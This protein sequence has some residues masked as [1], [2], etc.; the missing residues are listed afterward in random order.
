[1][2]GAMIDTA[3]R[4]AWPAMARPLVAILRGLEPAN[5]ETMVATLI[6]AGF[7][8]IE[9][10]LNSPDAFRSIETAARIAPDTCLIGAGTVLTCADVDRLAAA[11]G[12][13]MVSPNMATDVI[14]HAAA[15]SLV[16]MPGVMTPSEA[17]TALGAG[18][19]ALK[20]FPATVLGPSGVGA[21][22][23]VLPA[24]TMVAAVGGVSEVDFGAYAAIGV[25]CFGLGS[26]LFKPGMSV[27]T[28]K[29]RATAAIAAYDAVFGSTP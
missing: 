19:S 15:K 29:A 23:A 4:L 7:T 1:M 6:E 8:A 2:T 12:R 21:M 5:A 11:G 24:E 28:V 20:V 18:A 22:M 27:D 17:F 16:T 14:A 9:V 13:L 3:S 10:P 25:R 26:S